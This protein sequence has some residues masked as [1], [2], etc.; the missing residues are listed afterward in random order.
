MK[1]TRKLHELGQSIWLDNITRDLVNDG[2]LAR[3]VD[4]LFVTGLTSNPTIFDHAIESS[5][6]AG[7][8]RGR[9]PVGGGRTRRRGAG[10]GARVGAL[11]RT[12]GAR[13]RHE[14]VRCVGPLKGLQRKYGFEPE[15]VAETASVLVRELR[16]EAQ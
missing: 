9:A 5:T 6:A 12:A 7:V 8:P 15:R 4:E 11:R 1:A 13:D 14:G 16:R 2:A 10:G 3:Y